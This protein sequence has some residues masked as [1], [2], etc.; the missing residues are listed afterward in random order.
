M[1][2]YDGKIRLKKVYILANFVLKKPKENPQLFM[3]CEDFSS[4]IIF[5]N[6]D[7]DIGRA[8]RFFC[9]ATKRNKESLLYNWQMSKAKSFV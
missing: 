9:A 3:G 5:R 1:M 7:S 4:K 6:L 2:K 8:K